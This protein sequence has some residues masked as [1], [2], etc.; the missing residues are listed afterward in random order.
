MSNNFRH[1][2]D[3]EEEYA[4]QEAAI[5]HFWQEF[6]VVRHMTDAS[7]CPR[8]EHGMARYMVGEKATSGE[9]LTV[10]KAYSVAPQPY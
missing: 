8:K 1:D 7:A 3:Q 9:T 2:E 6:H 10:G 5:F 4:T